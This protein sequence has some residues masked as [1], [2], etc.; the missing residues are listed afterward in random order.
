MLSGLGQGSI[1]VHSASAEPLNEHAVWGQPKKNPLL[2]VTEKSVHCVLQL[3]RQRQGG[4]Q[5]EADLLGA[6]AAIDVLVA[7]EKF[8]LHDEATLCACRRNFGH[9]LAIVQYFHL[10]PEV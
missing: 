10:H 6:A 3:L 4:R 5:R 8:A 2:Q 9:S 7:E 1:P